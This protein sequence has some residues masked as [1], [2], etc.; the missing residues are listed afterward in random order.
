MA[1]VIQKGHGDFGKLLP[2]PGAPGELEELRSKGVSSG[3]AILDQVAELHERPKEMMGRT[4]G[5]VGLS[6]DL[7]QRGRTSD[8][9]NDFDDPQAPFQGLIGLIEIHRPF[10][11]FHLMKPRKKFISQNKIC[12]E[13]K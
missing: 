3:I 11:E 12:Q 13:E 9:G 8:R 6:G 10:V 2:A 5:Q 7:G 1:Q 4:P